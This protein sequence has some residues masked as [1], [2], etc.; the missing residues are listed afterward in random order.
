MTEQLQYRDIMRVDFY[1]IRSARRSVENL[2]CQLC[3]KAFSDGQNVA[4]IS[5]DEQQAKLIDD[6]LWQQ[7]AQRFIPHGLAAE[8]SAQHAPVV[9]GT[10]RSDSQIVINLAPEQVTTSP[11]HKLERILE[12]VADSDSARAAARERFRGYKQQGASLHTHELS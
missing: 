9:I 2:C 7:P 1:L 5:T 6:L 8:P 4:I 3:S 10:I 11:G 12:I